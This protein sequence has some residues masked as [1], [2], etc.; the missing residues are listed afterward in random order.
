MTQ[1]KN[2]NRMALFFVLCSW[3]PAYRV[4]LQ[5]FVASEDYCEPAASWYCTWQGNWEGTCL[6]Y[7]RLSNEVSAIPAE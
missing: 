6:A 3:L 5:R 1:E 4:V 2:R 7:P